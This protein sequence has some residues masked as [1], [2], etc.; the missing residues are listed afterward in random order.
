MFCQIE[1]KL[2]QPRL[3]ITRISDAHTMTLEEITSALKSADTLPEEALRAGLAEAD[4]LA[5]AVFALV[6]KLCDGIYLLPQENELLRYGLTLLAA[7]RHAG[8]FPYLLK[9]TRQP[10]HALGQVFPFY[11]IDNLARLLL[12]VWDGDV[13]AVFEAIED[14]ALIPEVRSAWFEVLAR[15]TFDGVISRDRTLA[16]LTRLEREKAIEDHDITWWGWEKAVIRLGATDLE[17]ALQRVWSKETLTT[18]LRS[19]RRPLPI[20]IVPPPIPPIPLYSSRMGSAPSTIL[21]KHWHGL[22]CTRRRCR[23]GMKKRPSP[24]TIPLKRSA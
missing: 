13:D 18:R 10:A 9:L 3:S 6:D 24:M 23:I 14:K 15:L 4:Q 22:A 20:C 19:T 5:P 16:F 1:T 21:P 17:P 11:I 2:I 8:L 12:S 7:A